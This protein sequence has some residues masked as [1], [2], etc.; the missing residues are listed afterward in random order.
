[1]NERA[2][3]NLLLR[4]EASL[5][6]AVSFKYRFGV[7][8]N[9]K[10]AGKNNSKRKKTGGVEIQLGLRISLSRGNSVARQF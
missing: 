4:G 1:V 9:D 10:I 6:A 3:A 5:L 2:I 8:N 7:E